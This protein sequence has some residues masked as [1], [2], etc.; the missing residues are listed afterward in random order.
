MEKEAQRRLTKI[1]SCRCH[2]M[3]IWWRVIQKAYT[4]WLRMLEHLLAVV[5]S[6]R[7]PVHRKDG[8]IPEA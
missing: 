7:C 8:L 5:I 4:L 3:I 6:C 2:Q 1:G